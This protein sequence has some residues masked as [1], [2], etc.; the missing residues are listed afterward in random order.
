MTPL[1]VQISKASAIAA[2]SIDD[3]I[4]QAAEAAGDGEMILEV[5]LDNTNR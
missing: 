4:A 1:A 5:N 2:E 3:L